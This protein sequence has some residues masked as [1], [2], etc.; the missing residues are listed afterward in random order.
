[1]KKLLC[2]LL[3]LALAAPVAAQRKKKDRSS[4]L[5]DPAKWQGSVEETLTAL[6]ETIEGLDPDDSR[7]LARAGIVR[8]RAGDAAGAAELFQRTEASDKD[9]DEAFA[10]IAEAY[11][12]LEMWDEADAWFQKALRKDADDADHRALWGVSLWN[13]GER[14]RA[15]EH[16]VAALTDSPKSAR[17]HF[18]IGDGIR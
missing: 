11:S 8:L 12:D 10:M 7:T 17:V 9:D 5:A 13:R 2:L 1:M 4:P 15:I 18:K 6:S 3:L 14:D 16:F